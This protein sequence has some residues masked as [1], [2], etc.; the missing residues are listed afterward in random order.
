MHRG[1]R[2]ASWVTARPPAKRRRGAAGARAGRPGRSVG[3]SLPGIGHEPVRRQAG[4]DEDGDDEDGDDLP[5]PV[6]RRPRSG[7]PAP[8]GAGS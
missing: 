4:A 8:E 7:D 1:A 5:G 3:Y 2:D 6:G